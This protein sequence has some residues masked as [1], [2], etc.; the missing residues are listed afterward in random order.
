MQDLQ[1]IV[2]SALD[3][4]YMAQGELSGAHEDLPADFVGPRQVIHCL[5]DQPALI[6]DQ[7]KTTSNDGHGGAPTRS[8]TACARPSIISRG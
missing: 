4:V 7:L 6:V 2:Q 1:E 8:L 5:L 3:L